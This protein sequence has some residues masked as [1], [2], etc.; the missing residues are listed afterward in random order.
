MEQHHIDFI[1]SLL[2]PWY[3]INVLTRIALLWFRSNILPRFDTFK[4]CGGIFAYYDSLHYHYDSAEEAEKK[5][6]HLKEEIAALRKKF[7]LYDSARNPLRSQVGARLSDSGAE[8]GGS[9]GGHANPDFGRVINLGTDGI[10][11]II[12][13]Y[14]EKNT[15]DTDWFYRGCGY[16]LD[17]LDIL[18][19]RDGAIAR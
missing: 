11:E 2:V 5:Y 4:T 16:A 15:D 10:R 19:D 1:R 8:W 12:A 6:P 13:E 14:R 3:R 17:A 7:E 18:G 9:F